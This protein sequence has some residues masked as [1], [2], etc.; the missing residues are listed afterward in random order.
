MS[1]FVIIKTEEQEGNTT[2]ITALYFRFILLY[3][4]SLHLKRKIKKKRLFFGFQV[5]F[6]IITGVE[7]K[8][9]R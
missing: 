3:L 4:L 2:N 8:I 9:K 1:T 5:Y 6:A 7:V